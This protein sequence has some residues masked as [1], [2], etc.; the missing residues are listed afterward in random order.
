MVVPVKVEELGDMWL[1]H[2]ALGQLES[3]P[4]GKLPPAIAQC[5]RHLT[6]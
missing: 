1:H 4:G 5:S 6:R 2:E 3:A